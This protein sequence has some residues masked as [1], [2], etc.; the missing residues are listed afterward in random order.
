[1][2]LPTIRDKR[3]YVKQMTNPLFC[4]DDR[5]FMSGWELVA[6]HNPLCQ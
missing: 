2:V 4:H 6:M 5:A 1:M 3:E